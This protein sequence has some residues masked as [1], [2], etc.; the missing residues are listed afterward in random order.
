MRQE[1]IYFMSVAERQ[2]TA[3]ATASEEGLWWWEKADELE[4]SGMLPINLTLKHPFFRNCRLCFDDD[5]S[6]I[7]HVW[8]DCQ[9]NCE[10]LILCSDRL[11]AV[12][13]ENR[14]GQEPM[15]W[16]S[17]HIIHNEEDRIYY[18]PL[19]TEAPD[20]LDVDNCYYGNR[21]HKPE[22][23]IKP[24]FDYSKVKT[25]AIFPLNYGGE[26]NMW[27]VPSA[28]YVSEKLK[29]AIIKAGMQKGIYFNQVAV[30]YKD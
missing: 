22:N 19:F 23:I 7:K 13:D 16:I 10:L 11:K 17:C 1:K 25:Y 12:I 14:T 28:V 18:F 8:E 27:R 29:R 5:F 4:K 21:E 26:S 20:V 9:L 2:Q 3:I 15:K 6:T 24:T 30:T